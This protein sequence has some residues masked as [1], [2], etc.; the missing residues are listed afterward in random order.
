MSIPLLW[1]APAADFD[2]PPSASPL[3]SVPPVI[4]AGAERESLT[5][6]IIRIAREH[7]VSPRD[8]IQEVFG[9]HYP[10]IRKICKGTFFRHYAAPIN[11]LGRYA[12]LF[13]QA[14][15]RL[16]T[17]QNLAHHTLLPLSGAIAG[18]GSP[19]IYPGQRWCPACLRERIEGGLPP[20]RPLIW[21]LAAISQCDRHHMP[22]RESC[23]HCGAPQPIFPRWPDVAFCDT[24]REPLFDVAI[25]K[26]H[27]GER[28]PPNQ[29]QNWNQRA[30]FDLLEHLHAFQG[31]QNL[32]NVRNILQKAI[33]ILCDGNRAEFCR[34]VG[35][36]I[37]ALGKIMRGHDLPAFESVLRFGFA[38][39]LLPSKLL[40]KEF[41][42]AIEHLQLVR[43]IVTNSQSRS[44]RSPALDE[45]TLLDFLSDDIPPPASHIASH[46]DLT[47]AGLKYRYTALYTAIVGKR[48]ER[49]ADNA[50]M[51]S[52]ER[53]EFLRTFVRKITA[54]GIYPGKDMVESA[55]RERG[56]SLL[57]T[58]LRRS[59][60]E[61]II[62]LTQQRTH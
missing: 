54:Q 52:R 45:Q 23:P 13:S 30:C 11:G 4:P 10:E 38:L 43:R 50:Q 57:R 1:Q 7:S 40:L 48:R 59:Y 29:W 58:E 34:Q 62:E 9:E 2:A 27:D 37:Y 14:L 8:M 61:L 25:K 39:D 24:C 56:W 35:L 36:S 42:P 5:S 33:M 15:E 3:Y 17:L 28:Q 22:L 46:L 60:Y 18:Q 53:E 6:L 32:E 21:S 49:L 47:R 51:R 44:D 31:E 55:L 20:Y 12:R 26:G 16:A 19:V 41:Q